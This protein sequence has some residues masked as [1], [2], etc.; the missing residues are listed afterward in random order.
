MY[1][2]ISRQ[3][4]DIAMTPKRTIRKDIHLSGVGVHSGKNVLLALKPSESGRILFRRSD[5]GN[6]ESRL[7]ASRAESLNSTAHIGEKFKVQTVEHLLAALFAF[8]INS[9]VIELDADEVPILDGSALPFARALEQAGTR[10]LDQKIPFLKITKPFAVQE[11]DA[12]IIV[13]PGAGNEVL[14]LTYSIEYSH[15]VIG[16]QSLSLPFRKDRKS[17][18]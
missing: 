13:E 5:L 15:P 14:W 8:G 2:R 9:L 4:A 10:L 11:E 3:G 1:D 6:L 12:S 18:V 16:I 17:V 7:D